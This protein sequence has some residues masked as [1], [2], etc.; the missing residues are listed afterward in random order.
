V[1]YALIL[2][3]ALGTGLA[4][5]SAPA[6]AA[7]APGAV[8]MAPAATARADIQ[9]VYWVWHHRHWHHRAWVA[10]LHRWRYW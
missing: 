7:L 1:K 6:E 10:R 9:P 8:T 2:C 3:T 5:G 4:F